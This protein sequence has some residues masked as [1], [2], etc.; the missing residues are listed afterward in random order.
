MSKSILIVGGTG[1][2]GYHL[3]K[4]CMDRKWSVVS[5]STNKPKKIRFLPNIKYLILDI[6][7]KKILKN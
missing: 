5:I 1:F 2:L 4:K 3:A 7:K 6:S